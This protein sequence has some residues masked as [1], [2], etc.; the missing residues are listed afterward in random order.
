L[1]LETNV[2]V[3]FIHV[4]FIKNKFISDSNVQEPHLK[5]MTLSSMLS[6]K[7]KKLEVIGLSEPRRSQRVRKEKHIDTNFFLLIQLY[8]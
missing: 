4:K 2:I 7:H 8:F 3:K 1:D 5:V 6:E